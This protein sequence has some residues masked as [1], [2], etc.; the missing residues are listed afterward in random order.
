[1]TAEFAELM[2]EPARQEL[3][4]RIKEDEDDC[5][6]MV[7]VPRYSSFSYEDLDSYVAELLSSDSYSELEEA[8]KTIVIRAINN[9]Y[10]GDPEWGI[11]GDISQDNL[12]HLPDIERR[13][14][15]LSGDLILCG[16][17]TLLDIDRVD[18]D[19]WARNPELASRRLEFANMVGAALLAGSREDP[20][21]RP[22][23]FQ[24]AKTPFI[25]EEF[26]ISGDVHG[27]LRIASYESYPGGS[28]DPAGMKVGYAP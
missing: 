11:E 14:E 16:G 17:F 21:D 13:I 19:F 7:S 18:S 6:P 8:E 9:F 12:L 20:Q 24:Y 25:T 3:I 27:D 28:I 5:M 22:S 15:A 4:E 2:S 10:N 1:M 23:S 26:T